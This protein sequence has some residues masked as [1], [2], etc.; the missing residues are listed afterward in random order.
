E[1]DIAL[2]APVGSR[3][4]F[5]VISF[6]RFAGAAWFGACGMLVVAARRKSPKQPFN[7]ADVA[8]AETS[9]SPQPD[10]TFEWRQTVT[11]RPRYGRSSRSLLALRLI[12]V[13]QLDY[14]GR[15]LL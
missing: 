12:A 6:S 8:R 10:Q 1:A 11:M 15:G 2:A 3:A 4:D 5:A 7:N 9:L 13:L 14:P